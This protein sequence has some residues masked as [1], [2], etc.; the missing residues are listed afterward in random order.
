VRAV[1]GGCPRAFRRGSSIID[2]RHAPAADFV[3]ITDVPF[4]WCERKGES[5]RE[6]ARMPADFDEAIIDGRH[7]PTAGVAFTDVVASCILT[8]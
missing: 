8:E 3:A 5:L 2:G 4:E 6:G 7:A 1:P